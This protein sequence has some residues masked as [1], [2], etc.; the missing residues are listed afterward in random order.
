MPMKPNLSGYAYY[1]NIK[2]VHAS[3]HRVQLGEDADCAAGPV[4]QPIALAQG[5]R[6]W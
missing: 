6:S 2:R 3:I 4:S 5:N 1:E